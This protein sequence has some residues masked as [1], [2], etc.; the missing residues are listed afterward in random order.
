MSKSANQVAILRGQI[1]SGLEVMQRIQGHLDGF[2]CD[3]LERMGRTTVTAVVISDGLCRF[4]TAVETV[5]VRIAK[6]FENSLEGERWHADLLDR[7]AFSIPDIRP[8]VIADKT[9]SD[10]RE[11]MKFRHFSRYYVELEYDWDRLDFLLRKYESIKV[12]LRTDIQAFLK[13]MD[14]LE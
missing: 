14:N 7:M 13:I 5:F 4:Y 1:S 11:I 8:R 12:E 10:L 9:H 3:E 6:F 2:L